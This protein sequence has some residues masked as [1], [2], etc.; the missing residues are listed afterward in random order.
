MS[1]KPRPWPNVRKEERDQAAEA[2]VTG[3]RALA[4]LVMAERR[5]TETEILRRQAVALSSLHRIA[6]LMGDAGA[7]IRAIDL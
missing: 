7:P 6:R 4:P 5:F 1:D 2:A 3:I